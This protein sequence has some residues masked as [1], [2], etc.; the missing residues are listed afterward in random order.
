MI[1]RIQTI[2]LLVAVFLMA[3]LFSNP[4]AE[5]IINNS[6]Y[7]TLWHNKIISTNTEFAPHSTWPIT[8][9]LS[10]IILIELFAVFLYKNRQLQIRLCV[11][12]LLLM[13]GIVGLIY[14]FTKS[15]LNSMEGIRSVFL[16]PIVCPMIAIILNYLALKAIQK[17]EKLVHSYDR[18]R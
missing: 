6:L 15:T 7:L 17:D 10:V 3:L 8:V 5:I 4:I 9:L 18:I 13:F 11:F 1:Q 14:F 2:Y 16:W 12:N